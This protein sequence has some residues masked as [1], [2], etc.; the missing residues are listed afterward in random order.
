MMSHNR[1]H[2]GA[3]RVR[4]TKEKAAVTAPPPSTETATCVW[5]K[6]AAQD[7]SPFPFFGSGRA[8]QIFFEVSAWITVRSLR[9]R[10]AGKPEKK[11]SRYQLQFENL[12]TV[13]ELHRWGSRWFAGHG[14]GQVPRS[15]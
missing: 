14:A 2:S 6:L 7:S 1:S 11:R 5:E 3:D 15:R 9:A 4:G 8:K 12:L 10:R 13:V